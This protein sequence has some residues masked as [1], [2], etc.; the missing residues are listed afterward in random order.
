MIVPESNDSKS[1]DTVAAES[2]SSPR[3]LREWENRIRA[4]YCSAGLAANLLHC[5]I[6]L[7]VSPDTIDDCHRIVR[8][9][10]TH[11]DLS[12][13]VTLAAGGVVQR[14][15]INSKDM[16][17][18]D[19][20][21]LQRTL[22]FIVD[23]FCCG[24]TI[25]RPLFRAMLANAKQP[26][27]KEVI[28]TIIR[29]EARHSAFGWIALDELLERADDSLLTILRDQVQTSMVRLRQAYGSR[30]QTHAL[31]EKHELSWGLLQRKEY[32]EITEACISKTLLPRFRDR[33]LA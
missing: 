10:L 18:G 21:L 30:D 13:D 23:F 14:I 3:V 4:E 19:G 2:L 15:E 1:K 25:A 12:R 5:L 27:A 22:L 28:S 8:D 7:G 24:E 31:L 6:V 20:P 32:D 29:D 16:S 17:V 11:A 26:L 33:G 9:E